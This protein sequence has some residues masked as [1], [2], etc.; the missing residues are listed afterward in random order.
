MLR[1]FDTNIAIPFFPTGWAN[2]V[3]SW[4][5]GLYS[6]NGTI[7]ISNTANPTE[8]GGCAIDVDVES[9]YRQLRGRIQQDFVPRDNLAN[10]MR[11]MVGPSMNVNGGQLNVNDAYLDE[12]HNSRSRS[13]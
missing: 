7:R 3:T 1:L 6:P 13:I 10:A 11:G 12:K 5:T 9:L 8:G 4:L 2:S